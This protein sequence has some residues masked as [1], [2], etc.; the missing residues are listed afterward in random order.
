MD[1]AV[2]NL[3]PRV[4]IVDVGLG[5]VGSVAAAFRRETVHVEVRQA[6]PPETQE[7][8]VSHLVLPGQGSFMN[9]MRLL[10]NTG[11][12]DWLRLERNPADVSILG[13]CLG[14]QLLA[15]EGAEGADPAHRTTPGLDLI[16]GMVTRM[17]DSPEARLP[18]IGWN[19]V[20]WIAGESKLVDGTGPSKDCYFVHSY[21]F[22]PASQEFVL[23]HFHHGQRYVAAVGR[24]NVFGVQ[25]HP[26]KSQRVGRDII[27]NFLAL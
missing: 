19:E 20:Q 18:H 27:R 23:A 9:G 4:V 12:V 26:E 1:P 24:G 15:T 14:M 25:F 3:S 13:I 7:G 16:G 22:L 6:P 5:N 21:S 11:W 2:N 17:K 8:R 10:G